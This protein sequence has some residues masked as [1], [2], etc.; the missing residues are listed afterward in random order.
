MDLLTLPQGKCLLPRQF[1][2]PLD[3]AYIDRLDRFLVDRFL[4]GD[5]RSAGVVSVAEAH[6]FTE[7]KPAKTA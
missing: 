4:D 5:E 7:I 2:A 6:W 3:L 1:R